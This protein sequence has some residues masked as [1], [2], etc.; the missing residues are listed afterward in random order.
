MASIRE[1]AKAAN[2][3]TSA[4]SLILRG[5]PHTYSKDTE[6]RV[7]QA[8]RSLNYRPRAYAQSMRSG[9]Y[10][11][12]V[13]IGG[14]QGNSCF[15]SGMRYLVHDTLQSRGY[16]LGMAY[17]EN[18]VF[19]DDESITRFVTQWASDGFLLAFNYGLPRRLIAYFDRYEI[20]WVAVN[21]DLPE[22]AVFPDDF[23]AGQEAVHQL[24][25][26]GHRRILYLDAQPS[27]HP[28]Y[29]Q[30]ARRRGYLEAMAQHGLR[31]L[32][33]TAPG[34]SLDAFRGIMAAPGGGELAPGERP[35]GFITYS[36]SHAWHLVIGGLEIGLRAPR[37]YSIISFADHSIRNLD[38][39]I[40]IMRIPFEGVGRTS[41]GMLLDKVENGFRDHPSIKVDHEFRDHGGIAPPPGEGSS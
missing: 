34:Q 28:H 4:V 9:R 17:V 15:Q 24:V 41:V 26:A 14:Q 16:R 10:H 37:D 35:T 25:R 7:R 39:P 8:A 3:P 29:S 33:Q 12:V 11:H 40:S 19:Q 20:P 5:K 27:E 32:V 1:V 36:S 31:A 30:D 13:V 22:N 23:A 18:D 2:A 38:L 21:L 6:E